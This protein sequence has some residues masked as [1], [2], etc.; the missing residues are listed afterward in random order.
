M[1]LLFQYQTVSVRLLFPAAK[2]TSLMTVWA[3]SLNISV[4]FGHERSL[5]PVLQ[6][7]PVLFKTSITS[8]Q[9]FP[10]FSFASEPCKFWKLGLYS[11]PSREPLPLA[12][13]SGA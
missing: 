6:F 7:F 11:L 1:T 5:I 9:G 13:A 10:T 4:S 8:F 2:P 3:E 12:V